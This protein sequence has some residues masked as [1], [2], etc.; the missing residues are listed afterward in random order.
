MKALFTEYPTLDQLLVGIAIFL[1]SLIV[2]FV[3]DRIVIAR[4]TKL[5]ESTRWRLDEIITKSLRGM[6]IIWLGI[7]G[8]RA[9]MTGLPL[10][11][12]ITDDVHKVLLALVTLSLTVVLARMAAG[13]L[14][15]YAT[16]M[17]GVLP[18]TSIFENLI[19]VTIF[20]V[21][22]LMILQTFGVPITPILTTLGVGG[23]AVALAFQPTLTNLF[24]G[25]QIILARQL[26]VGDFI[27]Y[28]TTGE[29]GYVADIT[30][31]TT[32]IR[33]LTDNMIIVPN[34][35]LSEA[36]ITN[37]NQPN[38]N[39][40]VRVPVGVHYDSDLDHVEKVTLE[41]AH[42]V[43]QEVPGSDPDFECRVRYSAFADSSINF[44]AILRVSAPEHQFLVVHEF[45]KR[46][47]RRYV[48]EGIE[49]PYPI[50]NLY[51]RTPVELASGGHAT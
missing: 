3:I 31:R 15:V 16:R 12:A 44:N 18:G 11:E 49:I 50:Q 36:V 43:M 13:A 23:L 35:K 7:I 8:F 45:I 30:W 40:S 46:L 4:L 25:L 5:A 29:R 51:M 17:E 39:L 33:T 27:E 34:S 21:G 20:A 32:T 38:P 48:A 6:A 22:G 10:K 26:K 28:D 14:R 19:K 9:G 24:A 37:F 1:G 47:N 42:E 2:G 41:V